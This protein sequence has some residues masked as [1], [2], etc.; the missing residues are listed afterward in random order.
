MPQPP[1]R[2]RLVRVR[3]SAAYEQASE[4]P[5]LSID[6][7][8]EPYTEDN[9]ADDE[10]RAPE[11]RWSFN[12]LSDARLQTIVP[13]DE[14]LRLALFDARIPL[15]TRIDRVRGTGW[16]CKRCGKEDLT[17]TGDTCYFCREE[18]AI[19]TPY[20]GKRSEDV[21]AHARK[22]LMRTFGPRLFVKLAGW[23]IEDKELCWNPPHATTIEVRDPGSPR[24]PLGRRTQPV[25]RRWVHA[26]VVAVLRWLW[27]HRDEQEAF[28]ALRRV[29]RAAQGDQ[30]FVPDQ[31]ERQAFLGRARGI[32][33]R[34][35]PAPHGTERALI[36]PDVVFTPY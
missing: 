12:L 23:M 31:V 13:D 29:A 19:D 10:S 36:V 22:M 26:E 5:D 4:E 17:D 25:E 20:Q 8:L 14:K 16:L 30:T 21:K 11:P 32:R 18:E 35:Q 1:S 24:K 9:F 34:L 7:R 28:L 27:E 3:R 6:A 2:A 33:E 15:S